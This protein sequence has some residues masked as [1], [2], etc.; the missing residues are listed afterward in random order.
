MVVEK[1]YVSC[2]SVGLSISGASQPQNL[3]NIRAASIEVEKLILGLLGGEAK[4]SAAN[5]AVLASR[6]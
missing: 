3:L 5:Q 1:T 4:V 2:P 6:S